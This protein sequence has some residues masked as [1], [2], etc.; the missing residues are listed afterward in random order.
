MVEIKRERD[1]FREKARRIERN[2][3]LRKRYTKF[4]GGILKKKTKENTK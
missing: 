4:A 1:G 3:K 2:Q